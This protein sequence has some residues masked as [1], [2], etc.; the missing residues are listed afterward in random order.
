MALWHYA[1]LFAGFQQ[2]L[3]NTE[4]AIFL[5]PQ[6]VNIPSAK[7]NL[8]DLYI[9]ILTPSNWSIR[10][11][12]EAEFPSESNQAGKST[13]LLLDNLTEGQRYELRVCWAATQPTAFVINTYE[14]PAVFEDP[15]LISSLFEY[16]MSRQ[17]ELD[18]DD[19]Q[20]P[21]VH[22]QAADE[23]GERHASV[24]FLQILAAADYF[25]ANKTLMSQVPPVFVDIILDPYV[26]NVLPR[27]LIPTIG[28]IVVVAVVSFFLAKRIVSWIR[29]YVA[30]PVDPDNKTKKEQ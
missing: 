4:K 30:H 2:V 3:A 24:L 14:L 21:R 9:D 12:I 13:W 19:E 16:S 17:P 28:Y 27:S 10:T 15:E 26:Y 8:D 6:T 23:E 1:L 29:G 5:G 7:P 22:E 18:S 11:H 25:T 20:K